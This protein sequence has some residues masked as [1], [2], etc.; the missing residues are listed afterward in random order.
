[1]PTC[2][3]IPPIRGGVPVQA[4][5]EQMRLELRL[6]Q[7]LF[8]GLIALAPAA[9]PAAASPLRNAS[10]ETPG[11][12]KHWQLMVL[13]RSPVVSRDAKVKKEGSYAV[14]IEAET[15]TLAVIQQMID[16]EPGK[17]YVLQGW[18]KTDRLM[19]HSAADMYGTL[20]IVPV[21]EPDTS[22]TIRGPNHKGTMDW[23]R[24]RLEFV[25]PPQGQVYII[26][27]LCGQGLAAG[28]IWFDGLE[29]LPATP[30]A[31]RPG[32]ETRPAAREPTQPIPTKRGLP[33]QVTGELLTAQPINP[34]I[35]GNFIESGFGRQV[36]G[37]WSEML[38][39]RSFEVIPPYKKSVWGWLK[40]GPEDDLTHEPWYHSGYEEN[41]WYLAGDNRDARLE[42]EPYWGFRH[43]TRAASVV[44]GSPNAPA[45]LAQDGLFLRQDVAYGLR[46]AVRIG[47]PGSRRQ[48]KFDVTVALYPEKDLSKAI[49]ADTIKDVTAAWKRFEAVLPNSTFEGRATFTLSVP[50]GADL[51]VDDLSLMPSDNVHGWRR[52]VVA[53]MKRVRPR[54]IRFPGGC[55]ASFYNWRDGIGP[56]SDR[57]PRESEYWGGL[58]YNDVGTAEF[59]SLCREAEAEPFLCVNVMTGTAADAADWVAY[60]NASESHPLGRLRKRHGYAAPFAVKY[61]ELDNEPYRKYGAV[62]YAKCCSEFARAMKKVDPSIKV[63][64]V[65]YWRFHDFLPQMLTEAGPFIDLV[66][67]RNGSEQ[68]LRR[69]LAM[70]GDY[71]VKNN[72]EIKLCNTEWLAPR[73]N[74]PFTPD[75]LNRDAEAFEGTLQDRQIRWRYAMNAAWQLLVF[76]RLG[77]DFALATF[78]NMANTWGQNVFECPKE[79]VYLSAAGRVFELFSRSPAAWPLKIQGGRQTDELVV[80]AAWDAK[81]QALVLIVLNYENANLKI[82]FDLTH[83]NLK[84][85]T[86]EISTLH[87]ASPATFNSLAEPDAVKRADTQIPLDPKAEFVLEAP[88][89]SVVHAVL[90]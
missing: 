60:C 74:M 1:V 75:A 2:C 51:R 48:D 36:D 90:K 58:E 67:D 81:K 88:P 50:A 21:D 71:N 20:L 8:A 35:Y 37:M 53:V 47:G 52:E 72:R 34:M 4:G 84:A 13:G 12:P 28:T 14:R 64:F 68:H 62:E 10:F 18:I 59:V 82:P 24:M 5:G 38:S 26:C 61:W 23:T 77:G 73:D 45:L 57:R 89:Y 79:G 76:Q 33:V 44:N 80:Q 9:R 41:P 7:M 54:I 86:V 3:K 49:V 63:V 66:T 11:L 25:G 22:K 31:T 32:P 87:A 85:A 56:R 78:N 42:F 70:I 46:G 83:L 40:R 65:G 55:F 6:S 69:A 27:S 19:L 15:E 30:A 29:L 43:G 39:N 16:V 17:P